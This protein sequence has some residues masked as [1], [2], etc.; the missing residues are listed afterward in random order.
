MV[1]QYS[2]KEPSQRQ[3]RVSDLIRD[4]VSEMILRG[5]LQHIAPLDVSIMSATVSPDLHYATIYVIPR[6]SGTG[7]K[8]KTE[9]K[10]LANLHNARKFI[11][12]YVA[13]SLTSRVCPELRFTKDEVFEHASKITQIL[14]NTA[15]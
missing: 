1:Q 10:I 5:E 3:K 4:L 12:S 11:R 8:A 7:K 6:P 13:Q 9:A 2:A 14:Q 15:L